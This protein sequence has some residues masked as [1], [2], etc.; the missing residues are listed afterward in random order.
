MWTIVIEESYRTSGTR[1]FLVAYG[2][3]AKLS[4]SRGVQLPTTL[5]QMTWQ[6]SRLV[7]IATLGRN[8]PAGINSHYLSG[9]SSNYL[10]AVI[11]KHVRNSLAMLI[12]VAERSLIHCR[13]LRIVRCLLATSNGY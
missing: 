7:N 8:R 12:T 1:T 4:F 11:T 5:Q 13:L 3:V 9:L 10:T 6:P 2:T